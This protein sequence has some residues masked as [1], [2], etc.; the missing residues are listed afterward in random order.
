MASRPECSW[1]EKVL[2]LFGAR[3]K[4]SP[5][6]ARL[7]F[8]PPISPARIIVA[9]EW[10]ETFFRARQLSRCGGVVSGSA[11]HRASGDWSAPESHNCRR[12]F[13]PFRDRDGCKNQCA[14]AKTT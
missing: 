11:H 3:R 5:K 6:K 9:K 13:R 10:Q 12:R 14:A 1:L 8:V 2:K 7:T 4:S